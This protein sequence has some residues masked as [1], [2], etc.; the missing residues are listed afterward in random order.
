MKDNDIKQL[1]A[2]YGLTGDTADVA[3]RIA[4]DAVRDTLHA[5]FSLMQNA[6]NAACNLS[7]TARQL[8]VFVWNTEHP[9]KTKQVD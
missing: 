4:R 6:N 7:I 2:D 5:Y 3:F 1:V 8:D 9:P